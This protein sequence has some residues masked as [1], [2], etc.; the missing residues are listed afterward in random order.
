MKRY[1]SRRIFVVIVVVIFFGALIVWNPQNIFRP[2]RIVLVSVLE[3][4]QK[5]FYAVGTSFTSTGNLFSD[6]GDLK[7][8]NGELAGENVRLRAENAKLTDVMEENHLLRKQMDLVAQNAFMGTAAEVIGSDAHANG[9]WITIDK[10]A[11]NG[12]TSGAAVIVEGGVLLGRVTDLFPYS[13]RITL[14]TNPQSTLNGVVAGTEAQGIV[15]GHYGLTVTLD[16]VSQDDVVRV[17]A[18][19]LT[20]HI[21]GELPRGL[22]I[23]TISDV[24][25]SAD[26]LFQIATITLPVD[27][28]TQRFVF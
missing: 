26:G 3:P 20:S 19:V 6:I 15:R 2:F 14:I 28:T 10:G 9:N 22:L 5:V 24:S 16:D 21:G 1:P 17:G 7:Q 11:K 27:V 18:D 8:R 4:V 25:P 23:G 13:A 12:V